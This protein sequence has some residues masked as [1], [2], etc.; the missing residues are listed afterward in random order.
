VQSH[1]PDWKFQAADTVAD[2]SLH[3]RLLVGPRQPVLSIASTA[4][5]LEHLLA[6]CRVT[7]LNNGQPVDSGCGANVLDSTRCAPSTTFWE[8]SRMP[9]RPELM[10]GD[11]VTT[12]TWTDAWPIAATEAWQAN[13]SAPLPPLA[14]GFVVGAT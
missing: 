1:L 4:G 7:L 6:D 11:V 8:N 12:G 2:G 10:P 9:R 13:F 5:A 14:V 3:A